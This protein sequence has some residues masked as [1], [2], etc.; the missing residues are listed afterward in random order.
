MDDDLPKEGELFDLNKKYTG[1]NRSALLE[2]EKPKA[3]APVALIVGA[4]LLGVIV[5]FI[6][7]GF[8]G[9]ASKEKINEYNQSAQ[10]TFATMKTKYPYLL[11]VLCEGSDPTKEDCINFVGTFR[12]NK[13]NPNYAVSMGVNDKVEGLSS[14][15]I[16]SIKDDI[17]VL[18]NA[19]RSVLVYKKP[20][21]FLIDSATVPRVGE[22]VKIKIKCK[23]D[24]TEI[25]V[26]ETVRL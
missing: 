10:S 23:E 19:K 1:P 21:T 15:D 8:G 6:N 18:I 25:V 17:K 3:K 11:N 16:V 14:A 20:F 4:V 2:A 9:S 7:G 22:E 5:F 24:D 26:C 12:P 13:E